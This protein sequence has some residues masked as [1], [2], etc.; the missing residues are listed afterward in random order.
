MKVRRLAW[1]LGLAFAASSCFAQMY[2]VTD[3]GT[4]GGT[5]SAAA[6]INASGQ[7]AGWAL[8]SNDTATHAFRTAPN[9]PINPATDDLGTLGPQS[10]NMISAAI[11]ASGQVAGNSWGSFTHAFRTAP[12]RPINPATDDLGTLG[13]DITEAFGIN[14]SGQVVGTSDTGTPIPLT[15]HAFRTAPNSAIKPS[16]DDLGTLSGGVNSFDESQA[17][18]IN[19]SGQVVGW[20]TTGGR[21]HAFRTTPNSAI[22]PANDDLGT[23]GGV[24]SGAVAV[25]DFGEVAGWALSSSDTATHAFR[26]AP[27]RP[28]N[29][30]TDDLGS[31]GGSYSTAAAVDNY[32]QV[33]G[34]SYLSDNIT[35][36]AFLFSGD[37]MHDLNSLVPADSGCEQ[38]VGAADI[39]AAGQIAANGTCSGQPHA[40]LLTPI[41]RAFVRPPINADGSSVFSAKRGVIPVKFNLTQY[42]IR[43][44][45]LPPA[46][47]GITKAAGGTLASVSE[48][49]Y[50]VEEI[51]SNCRIEPRVCQ[52]IYLLRASALGV[53][54]Y[55]VDI[56]INGVMVGHAVFALR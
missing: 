39:N 32:G 56:S 52:Y 44:C 54:T 46:T 27:N 13:A 9:R 33:V 47:I 18:G 40:V 11:N 30:A 48:S 20:S 8:S 31:L 38:L 53:G 2:T 49:A 26:T 36:H 3:L 23:L 35:Q 1:S 21:V 17:Y 25:N 14:D 37:V 10:S 42:S 51:G 55:R 22:N 19:A 34:I 6:G 7:V 15:F 4:L 24:N 50:S 29:P 28:I 5:Q 16:T 12:N 43:T 41:Y 45:T